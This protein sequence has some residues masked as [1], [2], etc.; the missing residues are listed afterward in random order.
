[1]LWPQL[2][3]LQIEAPRM[4][5]SPRLPQ[6]R[7]LLDNA[8]DEDATDR[9][10]ADPSPSPDLPREEE[11]TQT[12]GWSHEA[13]LAWQCQLDQ[14]EEQQDSGQEGGLSVMEV[15]TQRVGK[16]FQQVKDPSSLQLV[17]KVV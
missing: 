11:S 2:K 8:G 7:H 15:L 12:E 3:K 14:V 4:P 17:C 16:L 13:A 5:P 1:M 9:D 6:P 10:T